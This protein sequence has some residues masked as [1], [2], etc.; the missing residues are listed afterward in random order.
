MHVAQNIW[1]SGY[2]PNLYTGYYLTGKS[3][4]FL[5]IMKEWRATFYKSFSW[6]TRL[7]TAY[8][9]VYC[10]L[11]SESIAE[12]GINAGFSMMSGH[13]NTT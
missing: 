13:F 7:C 4:I 3:A 6:P 12:K 11:Q 2:I 1:Q 9:P 5:T 8:W 10:P